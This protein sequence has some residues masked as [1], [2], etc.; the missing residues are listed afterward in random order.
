MHIVAMEWLGLAASVATLWFVARSTIPTGRLRRSTLLALVAVLG[1]EHLAN[2]LEA[3]G[4]TE[5]DTIADQFSILPPFLW[6]LF[7]LETGRSYLS[8]RLAASDEQVRFFL[9]SVP[10]PVA[11]LD[12]SGALLG[13]SA[14]WAKLL[15]ASAPGKRLEQVLPVALDGLLEATRRAASSPV[16]DDQLTRE[17]VTGTDGRARHYRWC[18]RSWSH[19]DRSEP[20]VLVLLEDVTSEVEA[21]EQRTAAADELARAQRMAHV[22]QM[23]AGA[24][25]DFNNFLQVI[26]GAMWEL[27]GDPRHRHVLA[28]VQKTLDSAQEMTRAMLQFGREQ[29]ASSEAELLDL[30]R[31][32]SELRA[33]LSHALGRRHRLELA[34]PTGSVCVQGRPLRLQQAVLNLALN[35]RDAMPRGGAIRISLAADGDEAVLCVQDSGSGMSEEV[36]SRLFTPFFTTKGAHGSG[37]GLHVVQSVVSEQQGRISVESAPESGSTFCLRLPLAAPTE[38]TG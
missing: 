22:G 18:V 37:L 35:A 14:A 31:L 28:T 4:V 34:L 3:C 33:P 12:A 29:A 2:V 19:P 26:H 11:W 9:E 8:A 24:A 5:A 6:G 17:A 7:L 1:L 30:G 36:R 15:A 25:H 32:L 38:L 13:F 16:S 21:E 20:G 27:E 10:A 23:A